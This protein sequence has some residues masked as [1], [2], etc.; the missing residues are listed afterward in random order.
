MAKKCS[1]KV[2]FAKIILVSDVKVRCDGFM[3]TPQNQPAYPLAWPPTWKRTASH[4][5]EDARFFSSIIGEYRRNSEGSGYFP[6]YRKER[7]MKDTTD[8]IIA[9][10][11]RL[12]G[13]SVVIS[14]NVE[15]KTNGL[16]HSNRKIPEDPG[17]AVYFK[18]SGKPV[19]LACDKWKRV[20]DNLWAI[21]KDIE[22]QRGR[23]RWGVGNLEQAFAGYLRLAA[24]GESGAAPWYV[25]FAVPADATFETTKA[26]YLA[27]AKISHPDVPGGSGEAMRMLNTAWDQARQ[28]F[29]K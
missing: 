12:G 10:L 20:E 9:E 13:S 6:R 2:C 1:L 23:A 24:P 7:S 18:F 19:V 26:A 16:P 11:D 17:A 28:H 14:T 22:A 25:V 5:R 21:A 4:L 29:G 27:K 15:L 3:S 8:G